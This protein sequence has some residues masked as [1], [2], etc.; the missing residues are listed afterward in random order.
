MIKMVT[1]MVRKRGMPRE[2]FISYYENHHVPLSLSLFPQIK[3]M[4]RNYPSTDN[5]HYI[6]KA[7]APTV[8]FDVVTEHWF[9]DKAAYDEM[10]AQFASD[11]E[12]FRRSSEDEEK[13]SDKQRTIMFM[14]EE[15]ETE[16]RA[17]AGGRVT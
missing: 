3:K 7:G 1:V 13:F 17:L 15:H 14:V 11:P 8:P 2:E 12:K 9:E 4:A 5:F 10:M 16:E 6:G